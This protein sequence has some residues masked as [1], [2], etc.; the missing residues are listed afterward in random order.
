MT[1]K[2]ILIPVTAIPIIALL[3]YGLTRDPTLIRSPLMGRAA[4]DFVAPTLD[5]DSIG[6]AELEGKV[7][8]LNF[9]ASWCIPCIQE[10]PYLMEAARRYDADDLQIIGVIYQDTPE[11]ARRFMERH[12]GGW[13]SILDQD[14]R[15]AIDY[16]VYGVPETYFIGPDRRIAHKHIGPVDGMLLM[17]WIERLL[18]QRS[19]DDAPDAPDADGGADPAA[20]ATRRQRGDG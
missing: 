11:N 10:H 8:I 2:R 9:W 1:W 7:V 3:G 13:P 14:S 17:S 20:S 19:A 12:G 5:G 16:G 15:I 4:S 6:L 18:A